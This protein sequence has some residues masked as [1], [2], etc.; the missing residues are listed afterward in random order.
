MKAQALKVAMAANGDP[1]ASSDNSSRGFGKGRKDLLAVRVPVEPLRLV[2]DIVVGQEPMHLRIAMH[3]AHFNEMLLG[4]RAAVPHQ[5]GRTVSRTGLRQQLHYVL[6]DG[7]DRH[8]M[9]V[10][11]EAIDRVG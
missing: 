6:I 8:I 5:H 2:I 7:H 4:A 11:A 9:F 10:P 3:A 1:T